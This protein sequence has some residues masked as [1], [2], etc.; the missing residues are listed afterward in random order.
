M[1]H[2]TRIIDL[3]RNRRSGIGMIEL[4]VSMT[5]LTVVMSGILSLVSTSLHSSRT[6]N[7]QYAASFLALEGVEIVKNLVDYNIV[8]GRAFDCGFV[9]GHDYAVNWNDW[10]SGPQCGGTALG[11]QDPPL[12]Q[13]ETCVQSGRYETTPSCPAGNDL[14]HRRVRIELVGPG[15]DALRVVA[16]VS[17]SQS[18][19]DARVEDMFFNWRP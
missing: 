11:A 12:V 7:N 10:P 15:G 13:T 16:S 1:R 2:F 6:V 3:L 8:N 14:F 5:V 19:V 17:S 9:S 18:G 4:L